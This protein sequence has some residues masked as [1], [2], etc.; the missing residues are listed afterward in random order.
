MANGMAYMI[1]APRLSLSASGSR[2]LRVRKA[3]GGR[4]SRKESSVGDRGR[5]TQLTFLPIM[6]W[7]NSTTKAATL[8]AH[9]NTEEEIK[10]SEE[11]DSR[12]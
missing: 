7:I 8:G 6:I 3:R 9:A 2:K 4:G 1:Y 5:Q 10:K 11:R 12:T